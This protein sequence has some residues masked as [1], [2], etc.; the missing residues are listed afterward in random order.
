MKNKIKKDI[1]ITGATGFL[2]KRLVSKISRYYTTD[3]IL[4][5]VYNKNTEFELKGR[6]I[7]KDHRIDIKK[8]N[9]I[10]KE[11]LLDLPK[12]PKI[13]IHLAAETDTS[14]MDHRVNDIGTKNLYQAFGKLNSNTYFI[15]I[16]TMVIA[17][18]RNNC[19]QPINEESLDFPTNE[20][21]RTKLEGEKF[22]LKMCKRHN[23]KLIVL[24][25]NTIY[26]KCPRPGSLFDMLKTMIKNQSPITK[27][28]WPGKS[29]LIF[30]DDFADEILKF[31]K[32]TPSPGEPEKFLL[33][34]ESLSISEI[35]K[36]M[37][38]TLNIPYKPIYFSKDL[39]KLFSFS[40]RF[41]PPLEK[42]LPANIYNYFWRATIISDHAVNCQTNKAANTLIKWK[43]KKLKDSI[44]NFIAYL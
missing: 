42:L 11:G 41:V 17:A 6:K 21:T 9:L 39:W 12:N 38:K 3:R 22:L 28:N 30:I 18:G 8:V 26:G 5:L 20:Y 40:R 10:T 25:P 24:R 23:F 35:S 31:T 15:H 4:C 14:K 29:G 27:I 34:S 44:E 13:V 36:I 43:P 1:I 7:I 2:G 32:I 19:T 33:Y 37:H 16:S